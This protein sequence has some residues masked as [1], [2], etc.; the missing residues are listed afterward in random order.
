MVG[1]GSIERIGRHDAAGYRAAKARVSQQQRQHHQRG[2]TA[3]GQQSQAVPQDVA[4]AR[5]QAITVAGAV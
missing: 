1:S 5:P 3:G 2:I 4:A